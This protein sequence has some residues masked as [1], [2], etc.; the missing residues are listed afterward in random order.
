M[1]AAMIT[2]CLGSLITCRSMGKRV[3]PGTSS[4]PQCG[5]FPA[6]R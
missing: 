6:W 3:S 5:Q 1:S 2:M 4:W